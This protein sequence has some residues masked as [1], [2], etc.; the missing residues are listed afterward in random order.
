MKDIFRSLKTNFTSR[1]SNPVFGAFVLSWCALNING[2]A[3]FML[4]DTE[5]KLKIISNKSWSILDDV[6]LPL[7][8]ALLY[9]LFLPILNMAYEYVN[10]GFINSFRDKHKNKLKRDEFVRLKSTVSAK[11]EADEEYVRKLKEKEVDRWV[12]EKT[13]R[14]N[15]V[16]QLKEKYSATV[17]VLKQRDHQLALSLRERKSE[18]ESISAKLNDAEEEHVRKLNYLEKAL[19]GIQGL[20][21]KQ[22]GDGKSGN[23]E[24][25]EKISEIRARFEIV[26]FD[27]DIPF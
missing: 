12:E 20:N 2:V 7:G 22:F 9:L 25:R 23:K 21:E 19:N 24:L 4:S 6:A 5:N 27:D 13:T 18:V 1:F 10:D 14:N 26:D 8:I 16:I 17:A 15:E 11:I 3:T